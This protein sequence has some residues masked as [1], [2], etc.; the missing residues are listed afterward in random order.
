[1]FPIDPRATDPEVH[2]DPLASLT[3]TE[4]LR[5][6]QVRHAQKMEA[7]GQLAAGVAHEIN[8]PIQFV[9]DSAYFLQTAFD[10]L[11]AFID[12]QK[13][14]DEAD[15]DYLRSQ[16]PKALE[17]TIKG[18]DRVANIVRALKG[19]S[20]SSQGEKVLADPNR[21][22]EDTLLVCKNEYRYIAD[23]TTRLRTVPLLSCHPGDICQVLL[24]LVVNAAHA[25]ESRPRLEQRGQIAIETEL[26]DDQIVIRVS[27][28]GPGIPEAIQQ[29]IFEPFFTTKEVGRGTGQGLAIS[30]AIVVDGHSGRLDFET[31]LGKGTTFRVWL[32]LKGEGPC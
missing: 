15:L 16:I 2:L 32:P 10:D 3:P 27:D 11:L 1:M 31:E 7:V 23:V 19:F 24:N 30:R 26:V 12:G 22:V 28:D 5:E 6:V 29:R 4:R 8:T 20:Y 9:S 25:I 14:A 17:R 13:S 21:L 18:L